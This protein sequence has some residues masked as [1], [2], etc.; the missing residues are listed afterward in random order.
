MCRYILAM[1]IID[2][3]HSV[4]VRTV[5]AL[6]PVVNHVAIMLCQTDPEV[7]CCC[8]G[9]AAVLTYYCTLILV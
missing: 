2:V 6:L 7:S 9:V 3:R 4:T 1:Q 5:S 8:Q